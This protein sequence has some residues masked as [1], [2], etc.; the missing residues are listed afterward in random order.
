ML[1]PKKVK[2]RKQ[3][4]GRRRGI[5]SR[6]NDLSFG[7]YALQAM[8]CGWLTTRQIEAARKTIAHATK[9]IGKIWLRV[10]PDKSYT[11]K[12]AGVRMGG[13]KG[14]IEGYVCVI[15]PGRMLFEL[16]GV[17]A[18]TAREAFRLAARK[19]ALKTKFVARL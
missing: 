17:T 15:R 8:E 1:A 7:D 10:F 19:L 5:A 3:Q 12:G 14:E 11:K 4:K 18:E 13:G 9:R 6:G 2:Y 16:G